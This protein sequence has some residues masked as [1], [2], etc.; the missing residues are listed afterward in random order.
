MNSADDSI[1]A[2]NLGAMTKELAKQA[3]GD[4]V[5]DVVDTLRP[6]DLGAIAEGVTSG[7]KPAPAPDAGP[8]MVIVG[9]I[10]AMQNALKDDQELV[11]LCNTN[12]ESLRVLEIFLPSPRVAVLT[13][14]DLNQVVTRVVASVDTLQLTCKPMPAQPGTKPVRLRFVVPRPPV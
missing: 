10:Q 14:V 13:G 12:L 3:L 2:V 11:V 1:K 7:A 9:Q 4:R 8:G 6:P 5:K